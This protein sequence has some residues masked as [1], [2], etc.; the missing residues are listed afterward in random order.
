MEP[1]LLVHGYSAESD[2]E[3]EAAVARIFGN[4]P[5]DLKKKSSTR[6]SSM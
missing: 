2:S 1:V 3:E 4:L 5:R 6:R